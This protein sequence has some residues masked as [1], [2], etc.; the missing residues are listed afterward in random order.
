[1]YKKQVPKLKELNWWPAERETILCCILSIDP[2]R[3]FCSCYSDKPPNEFYS[4][5]CGHQHCLTCWQLYLE[6]SINQTSTGHR[7]SCPSRCNQIIDDEQIGRFLNTN[8]RLKQRY[9]HSLVNTFV[10]SNSLA[11]WCPGKSCNTI[12][13]LRSSVSDY[14]YKISCDTCTSIFCFHC[15]KQWHDPIQCS[16]LVKW[17]KKNRDESMTGEW[18]L[19]SKFTREQHRVEDWRLS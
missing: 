7:I 13:K 14:A 6:S 15:L 2:L 1:M 8:P 19:A 3:F 16:L 9:E 5:P 4:L 18:L 12:V 10:E 11:H 17:E